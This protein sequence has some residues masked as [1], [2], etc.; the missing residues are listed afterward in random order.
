MSEIS[1]RRRHGGSLLPNTEQRKRLRKLRMFKDR[2]S[3]YGVTAAGMAVVG[4]LALIFIYLFSEVSPLLRSSSVMVT[5]AYASPVSTPA[6]PA[7]HL[8]LERYEEIVASFS[9]SGEV[10][11]F[12]VDDGEVLSRHS[13]PSAGD[14]GG[15]RGTRLNSSHVRS[16]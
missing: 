11:F 10:A 16:S 9:R 2:L 14:A 1:P 15:R 3:R 4:A 8:V 13:G 6:D 12:R 5:G 7:E